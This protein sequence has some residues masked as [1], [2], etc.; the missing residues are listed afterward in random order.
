MTFRFFVNVVSNRSIW[1]YVDINC[2]NA[3]VYHCTRY[4]YGGQVQSTQLDQIFFFGINQSEQFTIEMCQQKLT[5][6]SGSRVDHSSSRYSNGASLYRTISSGSVD[7]SSFVLRPV[8]VFSFSRG[9]AVVVDI[10]VDVDV[11]VD[12]I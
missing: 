10:V 3:K 9:G 7:R 2:T 8:S 12:T 1:N 6:S 4:K 5:G 11:D